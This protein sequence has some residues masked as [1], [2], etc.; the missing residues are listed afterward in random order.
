MST[1]TPPSR[2][3]NPPV[4]P[5]G[6]PDNGEGVR[7]FRF[8]KAR[9]AGINVYLYKAGSVSEAKW[10]RVTEIDPI[11]LYDSNAVA[12]T[13]GWSDI[14]TVFWGGSGPYTLIRDWEQVLTDAGYHVDP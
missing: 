8:F 1:F 5:D 6:D 14:E 9:P 2:T 3:E 10:G 11:A 7:L 4:L 12:T 13:T